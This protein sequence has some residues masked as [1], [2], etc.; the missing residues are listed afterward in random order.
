M[1]YNVEIERTGVAP[2]TPNLSDSVLHAIIETG[3]NI[4]LA[5]ERLQEQYPD[6]FQERPQLAELAQHLEGRQAELKERMELVQLLELFSLLPQ[7]RK[8]LTENLSNLTGNDAVGAYMKLQD[9]IGRAVKKDEMTL[10]INDMRWKLVP[11]DLAQIYAELEAT[12][13]LQQVIEHSEDQSQLIERTG[14]GHAA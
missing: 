8:T 13:Q 12:G 6:Q 11:R 3:G 14:E 7:L 1:Q 2:A 5:Q 9:L 10:N 4:R